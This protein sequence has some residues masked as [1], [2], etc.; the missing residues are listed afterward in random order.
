MTRSDVV[1]FLSRPAAYDPPP[2]SVSCISTHGAHVFLAGDRVFK[3]KRP[4]AYDYMDFSSLERRHRMLCRELEI[5]QPHAPGIYRRL[6]AITRGADGRLA[7]GG[8]GEIVE[9][10][11]EMARFPEADVLSRMADAGRLTPPL[12][13]ALADV[14]AQYHESAPIARG[15]DPV[16]ALSHVVDELAQAFPTMTEVVPPDAAEALIA[17]LRT[18]LATAAETLR[19]RTAAGLVRR[20]HGDLHL[21]NIVLW[22]G[23]P[24]PF[25][26]IEFSEQLATIDTLYD[27]AFLLMD[28]DARGTR[29]AANLV[30]NRYLWRTGRDIDLDGLIALPLFLALR[31]GIRA[32]VASQRRHLDA[33]GGEG[34]GAVAEARARVEQ[35]TAALQPHAPRLVAIGGFSG[36]GKTTLARH[37]APSIGRAPGA[38]HLRSDLERKALFACPE[39]ERLPQSAYDVEVTRRVYAR[40]EGKA[41]R[42]LA[43]GQAVI[44]DA[45][46]PQA[47]E[48]NALERIAARLSPAC[49]FDGLWLTADRGNLVA[50]VEARRNDASD[51]TPA[52]VETQIARGAGAMAWCALNARGD[53]DT[54]LSA[55]RRKLGLGS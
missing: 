17:A 20:C 48:R 2:A 53:P 19:A 11:L 7:L 34:L 16:A 14:V 35:A 52:V 44:V 39:T 28:L 18:A 15:F 9:W 26:A 49:R 51:A 6:V 5:N 4:V 13:T 37:L 1:D 12:L 8:R 55:A 38:V 21:A 46:Y 22:H 23:V 32:M 31:A 40:L 3:I 54:V 50:R 42:A 41:Q 43:A 10:A 27:L 33:H 24:T 45:V 30:L 25:D 36:S 47:D 29:A